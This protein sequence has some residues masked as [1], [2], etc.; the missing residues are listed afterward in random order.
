[1]HKIIHCAT[2]LFQTG[3]NSNIHMAHM[4][5]QLQSKRWI[6]PGATWHKLNIDAAFS[7]YHTTSGLILRSSNAIPIIIVGYLNALMNA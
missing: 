1:M 6:K 3:I 4:G 5:G 7:G 2:L